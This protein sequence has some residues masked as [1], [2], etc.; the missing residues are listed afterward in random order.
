MHRILQTR[1]GCSMD[2]PAI[3][4]ST[5][6][7]QRLDT[8]GQRRRQL[9]LCRIPQDSQPGLN[10][11]LPL[12]LRNRPVV[13]VGPNQVRTTVATY[14]SNVLQLPTSHLASGNSAATVIG[15]ASR[16]KRSSAATLQPC[17]VQ[18]LSPAQPATSR[19]LQERD[20]AHDLR[21]RRFCRTRCS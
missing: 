18:P 15:F 2:W 17:N 20:I 7:R 1:G 14:K 19:R 10:A 6:S 12:P 9:K 4:S 5:G 21:S 16:I 11:L 3:A 13:R 8:H